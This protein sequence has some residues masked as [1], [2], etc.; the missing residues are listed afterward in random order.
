MTQPVPAAMTTYVLLTLWFPASLWGEIVPEDGVIDV[1]S[2]VEL[3]GRLV[4][5]HSCNIT[6]MRA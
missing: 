3:H 4:G 2:S 1:P 5:Y 6:C